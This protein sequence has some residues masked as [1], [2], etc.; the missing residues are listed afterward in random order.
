MKNIDPELYKILENLKL[1]E[2][3]HDQVGLNPLI[4][5]DTSKI[6]SWIK[7]KSLLYVGLISIGILVGIAASILLL[8]MAIAIVAAFIVFIIFKILTRNTK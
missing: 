2:K 7:I 3:M 8:P 5:E 1:H 6:S 4:I